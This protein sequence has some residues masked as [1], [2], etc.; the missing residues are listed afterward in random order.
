ML[1]TDGMCRNIY[2]LVAGFVC[3]LIDDSK[4]DIFMKY[5]QFDILA[6]SFSDTFGIAY[7]TGGMYPRSH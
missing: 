3:L 2:N 4:N 1:K 5:A 7:N 6:K